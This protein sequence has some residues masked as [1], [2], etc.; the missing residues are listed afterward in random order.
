MLNSVD[1]RELFETVEPN[2][3]LIV[4]CGKKSPR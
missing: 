2:I 4:E 3:T 1:N